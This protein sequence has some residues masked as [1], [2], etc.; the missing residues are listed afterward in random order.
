MV[1]PNIF[2]LTGPK[3]FVE[4][5]FCA[6]FRKTCG[7]EKVLEKRGVSRASVESFS[8]HIAEK[9]G[10]GTLLCCVSENFR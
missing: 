10:R 1:L 6:V 3:N 2:C 4:E 5:P 9:L 7:S 8:S